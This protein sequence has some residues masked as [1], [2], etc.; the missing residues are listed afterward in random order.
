MLFCCVNQHVDAYRHK[1]NFLLLSVDGKHA[2]MTGRLVTDIM[3][4]M[5]KCRNVDVERL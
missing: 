5:I 1:G 2:A 4:N 3:E